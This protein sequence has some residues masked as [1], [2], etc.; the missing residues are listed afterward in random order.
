MK[1]GIPSGDKVC[2]GSFELDLTCGELRRGGY[3]LRLQEK[4]F[5]V[6]AALL[7]HPGEMVSRKEL[8]DRL[9][10]ADTFVVF[11]DNLNTAV[12][13]LRDTLGDSAEHPRFIETIPRRG[14][15]FIAPVH[16]TKEQAAG[17]VHPPP[18]RKLRLAVLPLENLTGDPTQEYL[19]DG[20]TEEL[21]TQVA[22]LRPETLG[23]IARTSVMHFKHSG[24]TAEHICGELGVDYL[25]EGSLRRERGRVRV[26]VQLIRAGDQTHLWSENY[27]RDLTGVL[28]LQ[29]TIARDVARKIQLHLTPEEEARLTPRP[30]NPEAYQL[31]LKGHFHLNKF[32]D[33]GATTAIEFF[34]RALEEDASFAPAY[35]ETAWAYIHRGNYGGPFPTAQALEQAK[36][37]ALKAL[38]LDSLLGEAHTALGMIKFFFEWDWAGAEESF[39][40][41][42]QARWSRSWPACLYSWYLIYVG[43]AEEAFPLAK[44]AQELDPLSPLTTLTMEMAYYYSGQFEACEQEC[45]EGL[46]LY[47]DF[48]GHHIGL[49]EVYLVDGRYDDAIEEMEKAVALSGQPL[50]YV[51]LLAQAYA[52][53]G[54]K[55]E[56][57]QLLEQ[58]KRRVGERGAANGI[59]VIYAGLGQ[60]D[61]AME[62][63]EKAYEERTAE[64][65]SLPVGPMYDLLRQD[66][67]FQALLG[68]MNFPAID[69][70][71]QQA[72][73]RIHRLSSHLLR[74]PSAPKVRL[75]VLPLE[76][77]TGDPA[78]EY[79]SDG[80][81]EELITQMAQLRP[82]TLGVI[83]RTSVMH[84]KHSDTTAERVGR[85]LKVDYVLEG[86]LR[87][88]QERVRV[89][90]QLIRT[91]DQL[92]VW[93]E[94]YD[95]DLTGILDLQA[96]IARDVA[97]KIQIQLTPEEEARLVTRPV[98]AN[99]YQ[100]YLKG[101]FELSKLT[102]EGAQRALE[103]GERALQIAPEYAAAHAAMAWAHLVQGM[104]H[105]RIPPRQAAQAARPHARKALELDS[106]TGEAWGA[107][108][109][110]RY[111]LEWDWTGAEEAF[112]RALRCPPPGALTAHFYCWYLM[113]MGRADEAVLLAEEI[114]ES[115]PLDELA[116]FAS[117]GAFY[118]ARRFP[119]A[120][121]ECRKG[122]QR[123]PNFYGLHVVLGSIHLSQDR[124]DEAI[125]AF[126]KAATL[127]G[128]AV[129]FLGM[130]G[131]VCALADKR[132]AALEIA[133]KL[134]NRT[135][136]RGVAN[137]LSVIYAGLGESEKGVEFLEQ[138]YQE[139][140]AE[141][142]WLRAGPMYS[143]LRRHP[144]CQEL[145]RCMKF[146]EHIRHEATY[147][148][149]GFRE[150]PSRGS[151]LTR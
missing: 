111:F 146:P 2:F 6:L 83:A 54:R 14:Y 42:L 30:V 122:L 142:V 148:E 109:A 63:L 108:A 23:V 15:R 7:E 46:K 9:W 140:T 73:V 39:Q 53:A 144:R 19:S 116:L 150:A 75:A 22:Q 107:L 27:D 24:V 29:A 35:A 105:G 110:I 68:R 119:E 57:Q 82:E 147:P 115:D 84:F 113:S 103:F 89:T 92:H 3:K 76:N 67:R 70:S 151:V 124:F 1:V 137:A 121:E 145:I 5:Q 139:R 11:D 51:A 98:N 104:W 52:L 25:L 77:L 101:R 99:A 50:A 56:A 78:Q 49:A 120:E 93:L 125:D 81:T 8:R 118:Y 96:A 87:R 31:F 64:L 69:S 38:E 33:E 65:V 79:L 37:Y 112:R 18:A 114:R 34:R 32:T 62:W 13:K 149:P 55:K 41:G 44:Q 21:I 126:R 85:E 47:P 4:P 17:S 94:S 74:V 58:V 133:E 138:A 91:S 97:R 123:L 117:V 129:S 143:G 45:R 71:N 10:P 61:E 95:R 59:A 130:L 60:I 128:E 136:Q 141:L 40:R 20:L 48:Y 72:N 26:S 28:V 36:P 102:E 106:G 86:S 88:D 134:T 43:R 66:S 16:R 135:D 131:Q 127:S 12:K 132:E 90:V 100:L 80:L